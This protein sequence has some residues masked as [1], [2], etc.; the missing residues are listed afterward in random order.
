MGALLASGQLTQLS[1][2][3]N[4]TPLASWAFDIEKAIQRA[5][6]GSE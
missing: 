3:M 5:L 1:E 4:R 2:W 6:L